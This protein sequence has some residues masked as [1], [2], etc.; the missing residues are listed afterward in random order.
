[1]PIMDGLTATRM[2]REW[3][4]ANNRTPTPIIALTAAAFKGDQEKFLAAG[5][6]AY[7][8]KPIKEEALLQAIQDRFLGAPLSSTLESSEVDAVLVSM[9]PE[10]ADLIPEYLQNCRQGVIAMLAALDR[11]DFETVKF[12][13]HNMRGSGSNYG[14]R[15]ITD[16]GAALEQA[17][18]SADT[19][20]SRKWVG[21]LSSYLDRGET[22]VDLLPIVPP[23]LNEPLKVNTGQAAG[24]TGLR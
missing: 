20:A 4:Q 19:I 21:E 23:I 5:C 9:K 6:T 2:M 15:A 10:L 24:L 1:M 17:A 7:L 3:E 11:A 8:T 16:F 18:E 12:L 22:I 14:F 13:A